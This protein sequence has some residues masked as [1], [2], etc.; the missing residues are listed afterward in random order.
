MTAILIEL[1][2]FSGYS[3]QPITCGVIHVFKVELPRCLQYNYRRQID[4]VTM[5][6]RYL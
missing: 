5:L 2:R 1:P 3:Y 6:F 4:V